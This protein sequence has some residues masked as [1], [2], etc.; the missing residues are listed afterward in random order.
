MDLILEN[1]GWI[2]LLGIV[3][4]IFI[5]KSLSRDPDALTSK[6]TKIEKI[7][8]NSEGLPL[9]ILKALK[10]SGFRKVGYDPDTEKYYAQTKISIWS[11]TE[12]VEIQTRKEKDHIEMI[13]ISMCALPVQIIDWGKNRRNIKK[14]IKNFK[15]ES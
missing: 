6:Y 3:A 13:I 15:D 5:Y 11:W 12:F 1:I 10:E 8:G 7:P 4:F 2:L 14:S 9:K